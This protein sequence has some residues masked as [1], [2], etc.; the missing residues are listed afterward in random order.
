MKRFQLKS[1]CFIFLVL[2]QVVLFCCFNCSVLFAADVQSEILKIAVDEKNLAVSV[3]KK[4]PEIVYSQQPEKISIEFVDTKLNKNYSFSDKE[5]QVILSTLDFLSNITVISN[6]YEKDK[7]KISVVL[8]LK[9]GIIL[10]PK[11]ASARNNIIEIS[12]FAPASL[13]KSPQAESPKSSE[14]IQ[15]IDAEL[16]KAY[17]DAVDAYGKGELDLAEK[18]YKDL[19]V[20]N[21]MFYAARVNLAQVYL[22]KMLHEQAIA[23]LFTILDELQRNPAEGDNKKILLNVYNTLGTAYYLTDN[24][25]ASQKQFLE[26][27]K[28]D[29]SFYK[30][31]YNIGLIYEKVKNLKE[32]KNNLHK[33]IELKPDFAEAY[34]HLAKIA[35]T[36]SNKSEASLNYKKVIDLLPGSKLAQLS[37][38]E[39]GGIEKK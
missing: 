10:A 6:E 13:A 18:N 20:V 37:E 39:L 2:L 15:N 11:T 26:A 17:N 9:K 31:Y 16:Q 22:D 25:S 38:K 36:S 24:L 27:L 1:I 30:A 28:L 34:Y 3:A 35:Q 29:P 12:F 8:F 33:T 7:Y 14:Q 19:I 4:Y 5:K 32:A 21:S 23:Q